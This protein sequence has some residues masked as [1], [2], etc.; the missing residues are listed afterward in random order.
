MTITLRRVFAGFLLLALGL[1]ADAQ[2]V[3]HLTFDNAAN[4]PADSSANNLAVAQ[5]SGTPT[6]TASGVAGGA[7]ILDGSTFL[8]YGATAG[9]AF[10]G[11]FTAAV[12]I[13]TTQTFGN[14]GDP[15]Y[16]GA[17]IVFSDI[18][19]QAHDVIPVAL[20]GGVV[21]YHTGDGTLDVT[22]HSTTAINT[23]TFTHVA[24][25][26]DYGT[27]LKEIYINGVLNATQTVSSSAHNDRHLLFLGANDFDA[28]YFS[29][30][31]D[32]FQLYSTK[33]SAGQVSFIY[34]NPGFTAVP[35]PGTLA[36]LALGGVLLLARRRA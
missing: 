14:N 28:Q 31:L 9:D 29:G 3:M 15:A 13:N 32:D 19:G 23:G 7:V 34:S 2:L 4:L 20:N 27:G 30:Q 11:S 8:K 36:L 16:Y 24:V 1:R 18:P 6:Y 17:G 22:L 25:T 5:V 26:Y 12:W 21:G 35:E 10:A 33:L